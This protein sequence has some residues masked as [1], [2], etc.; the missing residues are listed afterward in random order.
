MPGLVSVILSCL[1]L[2]GLG[3]SGLLVVRAQEERQKRAARLAAV[4]TPHMRTLH[5]PLSAFT[6]PKPAKRTLLGST[7]AVFGFD[8]AR[9]DQYPLRWWMI[10]GIAL[11]IAKLAHTVAAQLLGPL[12]LPA[13]PACWVMLSRAA[14]GW[15]TERRREK[16]LQ[17]FPDALAMIVRSVGVGIPVMEAIRTVSREAPE[18]TRPEFA[19]LVEQVSIGV[20]L[21]DALIEMARRA[22]LPEYRFFATALALQS[23]TGGSLSATL[24]GLAD[25]IRKRLALKARG[26][27]LSSEARASATVLAILPVAV[28]LLLAVINPQYISVLFTDPAGNAILGAAVVSLGFGMLTMRSIIRRTLS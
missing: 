21:E 23:Q 3:V 19:R 28:G 16:L 7:A 17:Q 18:P 26:H 5:V 4:A 1:L 25:V 24:E 10:L 11:A 13:F 14:F 27:A 22:N 2:I 6:S 15:I 9:A 20:T 12:A 8:P